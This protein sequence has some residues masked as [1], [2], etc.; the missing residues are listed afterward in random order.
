VRFGDIELPR[1]IF[2]VGKGVH[3]G[4]TVDDGSSV[5][6]Y[7]SAPTELEGGIENYF[8]RHGVI[9]HELA[10]WFCIHAGL[11]ELPRWKAE[12]IAVIVEHLAGDSAEANAIPAR[13]LLQAVPGPGAVERLLRW[14]TSVSRDRADPDLYE[15]ISVLCGG[16]VHYLVYE[17]GR[18]SFAERVRSVAAMSD[19]DVRAIEAEWVRWRSEFDL[20]R[21]LARRVDSDDPWVRRQVMDRLSSEAPRPLEGAQKEAWF[22]AE[23]LEFAC[24]SLG[25][26]AMHASA[27]RYLLNLF[28]PAPDRL[29]SSRV[30]ELESS[31]DPSIALVGLA[32]SKRRGE[33]VDLQRARRLAEALSQPERARSLTAL[34]ALGIRSP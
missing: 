28:G 6:V 29:D 20:V 26:P 11:K 14:E 27:C 24:A 5:V 8:F 33:D 17:K 15:E 16:L 23:F 2:P 1:Y 12:G 34:E 18:G 21:E 22:T 7:V 31:D 30:K 25:D 13:G 10:H 19:A 32:L 3:G 4:Y 9:M